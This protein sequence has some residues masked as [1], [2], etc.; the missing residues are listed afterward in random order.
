M[1]MATVLDTVP[2]TIDVAQ[3]KPLKIG[4]VLYMFRPFAM[5]GE[6]IRRGIGVCMAEHGDTVAGS[7]VKFISKG[8]SA[9]R[10]RLPSAK[11][12]SR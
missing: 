11:R 10:R 12:N 6:S 7:K 9:S 8:D 4:L 3:A 1:K 2:L 5:F